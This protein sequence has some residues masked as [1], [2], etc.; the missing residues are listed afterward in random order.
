MIRSGP[1]VSKIPAITAGAEWLQGGFNPMLNLFR[2]CIEP[3]LRYIILTVVSGKLGL[4]DPLLPLIRNRT[5]KI[6]KIAEPSRADTTGM[7]V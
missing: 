5:N 3:L 6:S 4:S 2:F 1:G 7:M